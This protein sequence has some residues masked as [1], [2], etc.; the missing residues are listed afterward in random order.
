M[1]RMLRDVG[2]TP[3]D[4]IFHDPEIDGPVPSRA[5]LFVLSTPGSSGWRVGGWPRVA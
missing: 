4:S 2:S 1:T 5:R 3:V